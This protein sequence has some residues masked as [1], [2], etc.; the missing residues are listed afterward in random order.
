MS[1]KKIILPVGVVSVLTAG[2]LGS[3]TQI[4]ENK[5]SEI[6]NDT[7]IESTDG[8]ESNL[9][10]NGK[11]TRELAEESYIKYKDFYDTAISGR[12]VNVDE[13]DNMINIINDNVEGYSLDEINDSLA[14]VQ[15]ILLSENTIQSLTNIN[16][17][18][19]SNLEENKGF[20]YELP[21]QCETL[22]CPRISD[23]LVSSNINQDIIEY[24]NLRDELCKEIIETG[25]YSDD[26]AD[27]IRQATIDMET[28]EYSKD[29]DEMT[30]ELSSEGL[31]YT[32]AASNYSLAKLCAY[33]TPFGNFIYKEG[34]AP[35]QISATKEERE[36]SSIILSGKSGISDEMIA[37]NE[38]NR[39]KLI[40]TKYYETLCNLSVS[41]LKNAGYYINE[42]SNNTKIEK[43]K[44]EREILIEVIKLSETNEELKGLSLSM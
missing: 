36:L 4:L 44:A 8:K 22:V 13:I 5:K 30:T 21:E 40:S 6:N 41:I 31:S 1:F 34:G 38:L 9:I 11:T 3:L 12:N 7:T 10:I 15:Y 28:S 18:K 26:I 25:T 29:I 17:I 14:L 37:Q 16:S 42:S 24:E 20:S 2:T 32:I 19:A 33:A 39:Q 23:F 43:L 35:L 27:K